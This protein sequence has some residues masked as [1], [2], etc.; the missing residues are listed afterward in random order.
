M[1]AA[2]VCCGSWRLTL[3]CQISLV[4]SVEVARFGM[5]VARISS[6]L[7][8]A[9]VMCCG[10]AVDVCKDGNVCC[11]PAPAHQPWDAC[12]LLHASHT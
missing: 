4:M 11:L 3:G 1:S 5:H 2:A 8:S 12:V 9:A 6:Y 7:M 10:L